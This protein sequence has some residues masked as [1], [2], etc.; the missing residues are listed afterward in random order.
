MEKMT[1][2]LSNQNVAGDKVPERRNCDCAAQ[3]PGKIRGRMNE[4]GSHVNKGEKSRFSEIS[5]ADLSRQ[6]C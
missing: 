3:L 2:I 1:E 6:V 4:T 5:N